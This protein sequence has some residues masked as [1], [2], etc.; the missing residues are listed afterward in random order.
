MTVD[1]KMPVMGTITT[2]TYTRGD[3]VRMEMEIMKHKVITWIYDGTTWMYDVTENKIDIKKT[4]SADDDNSGD[5]EMFDGIND[6]YEVSIKSEDD[7]TWVISCKKL[8]TNKDKDAPKSM[9]VEVY[10]KDYMPKSLST[11]ASGIGLTMRD[12]SFGVK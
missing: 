6:G 2:R 8:K 9:V 5:T 10:K 3:K 11:K 7:R 1:M 12:I 4:S